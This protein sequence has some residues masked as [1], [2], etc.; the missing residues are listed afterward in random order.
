MAEILELPQLVELNRVPEVEIG[1]GRVEPFL[2]PQRLAARELPGELGGDQELVGAALEDGH[3]M[4]D[5]GGHGGVR[6]FL[7][8]VRRRRAPARRLLRERHKTASPD[9]GC[10]AGSY[11][12]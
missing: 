6:P 9:S 8:N 12:L 7:G 3:L 5:I 4:F 2:D 1:P 11:S 10:R